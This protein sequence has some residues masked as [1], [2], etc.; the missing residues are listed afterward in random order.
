MILNYIVLQ[1]VTIEGNEVKG[2][3]DLCFISYSY[4]G[5]SEYF[6]DLKIKFN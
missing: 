6:S 5:L 2:T 4:T 3:W 1:G